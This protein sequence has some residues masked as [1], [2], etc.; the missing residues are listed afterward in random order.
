MHSETQS[1]AIEPGRTFII[2]G[3]VVKIDDNGSSLKLDS[4]ASLLTEDHIL[5]EEQATTPAKRIYLMLLSMHI[6]PGAYRTYYIPFM[7][8]MIEFLRGCEIRE[9][10][11]GLMTILKCV[12]SGRYSEALEA[13]RALM[14]F[15]SNIL[16]DGA[17]AQ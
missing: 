12:E 15:E 17:V 4:T 1:V 7:D 3:A 10:R 13:C 16:Q 6:N 9:V 8:R 11:Q 2:N 5:T 14:L